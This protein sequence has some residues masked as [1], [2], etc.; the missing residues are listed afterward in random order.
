ML[1]ENQQLLVALK[2]LKQNFG[3]TKYRSDIA[4]NNLHSE[5]WWLQVI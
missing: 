4:M 3:I 5:K 2:E 1:E